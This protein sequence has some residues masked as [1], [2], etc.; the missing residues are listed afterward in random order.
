DLK[1]TGM[2]GGDMDSAWQEL[3]GQKKYLPDEGLLSSSNSSIATILKRQFKSDQAAA[4]GSSIAFLAEHAAG[5]C[6]F[7]ADAHPGTVTESLKRLLKERDVQRLHV[8]AVKVAHHGSKNNTDEA[9]VSLIERP[10]FLLS[11]NGVQFKHPDE[12]AIARIVDG[13]AGQPLTLYFNYRSDF[14]KKWNGKPLQKKHNFTAI[15][16]EDGDSPLVVAIE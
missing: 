9:L 14:N 11:T 5:S 1:A 6:L 10:R 16:G 15:Y 4:N 12:E 3:G 8:D 7:L 2:T 13:G